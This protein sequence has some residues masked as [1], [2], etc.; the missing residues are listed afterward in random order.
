[1]AEFY[2]EITDNQG[3]KFQ[4]IYECTSWTQTMKMDLS[5]EFSTT[6]PAIYAQDLKIKRNVSCY[7]MVN[8]QRTIIGSGIIDEIIPVVNSDGTIEVTVT[9]NDNLI[10]LANPSVGFI[11]LRDGDNPIDV[12]TAVQNLMSAYAPDGWDWSVPTTSDTVYA[13][14]AGESL[15]SC[16]NKLAE[17]TGHHFRIVGK[18]LIW[19]T[20]IAKTGVTALGFGEGGNPDFCLIDTVDKKQS[21]RDI[22][23][24]VYPYGAGNGA[25]R[26]DLF[27]LT[28]SMKLAIES[29]DEYKVDTGLNFI[30]NE[31]AT[32]KYGYKRGGIL[33]PIE[34][35]V[36]FKEISPV[37]NSDKDIENATNYMAYTAY[38]YLRKNSVENETYEV[39]VKNLERIVYPG[40]SLRVDYFRKIDGIEILSIEDDLTILESEITIDNSGV[41][42]NSVKLS[43]IDQWPR[44]DAEIIGNAI[45]EGKV[46]GAHPQSGPS[47]YTEG[48]GTFNVDSVKNEVTGQTY[49][50]AKATFTLGLEVVQINSIKLNIRTDAFESTAQNAALVDDLTT[51]FNEAETQ[52]TGSVDINTNFSLDTTFPIDSSFNLKTDVDITGAVTGPAQGDDLDVEGR[53]GHFFSVQMDPDVSTDPDYSLVYVKGITTSLANLYTDKGVNTGR[54]IFTDITA[55][56]THTSDHTHNL[57]IQIPLEINNIPLNIPS[58]PLVV[59]NIPLTF[60][61]ADISHNHDIA[62]DHPLQFGITRNDS[63]PGGLTVKVNGNTVA[64]GLGSATAAYQGTLD[65]TQYVSDREA[66]NTI[67]FICTSGQGR[68]IPSLRCFVITQAVRLD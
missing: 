39:T 44:D 13:S 19:F 34:K 10:E 32:N 57:D 38:N 65:I 45:E 15:L 11:E 31:T 50:T 29:N 66:V 22:V 20:S 59:N 5:G 52:Y 28:P 25:A 55:D 68:I 3:T 18:Q 42:T 6:M 53:H 51:E 26:L 60:T 33:R 64:T 35:H 1:M 37:S 16:L 47:I 7:T 49:N 21:G 61:G 4:P 24:R 30:E 62:H 67:E 63:Y 46:T 9:G 40:T 58:I 14:F 54:P 36:A 12:R 41:R 2:L 8:N 23:T 48:F 56:H 17:N 43:T 27:F